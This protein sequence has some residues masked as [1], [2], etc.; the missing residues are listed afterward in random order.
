MVAV[1]LNL[2]LKSAVWNSKQL[3]E[4]TLDDGQVGFFFD[5]QWDIV[6]CLKRGCGRNFSWVQGR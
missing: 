4:N 3:V 2:T 1:F 6:K 5:M